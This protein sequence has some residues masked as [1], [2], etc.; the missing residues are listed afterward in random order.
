MFQTEVVQKV[1]NAH[2][3]FSNIF[4]FENHNVYEIM[5]KNTV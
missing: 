5:W 3:T 2:F 1:Q 4:V